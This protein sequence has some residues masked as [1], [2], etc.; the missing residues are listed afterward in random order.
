MSEKNEFAPEKER[1]KNIKKI[2]FTNCRGI[3]YL[4]KRHY[5]SHIDEKRAFTDPLF[6]FK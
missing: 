2:V 5:E 6:W 1:D 4:F 3:E